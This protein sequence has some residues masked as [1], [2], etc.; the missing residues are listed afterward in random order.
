MWDSVPRAGKSSEKW[1]KICE[2]SQI[3]YY[4]FWSSKVEQYSCYCDFYVLLAAIL[5]QEKQFVDA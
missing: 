4:G 1:V 5:K 2:M 3:S